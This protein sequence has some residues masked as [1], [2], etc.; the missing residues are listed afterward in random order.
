MEGALLTL[1]DKR[2]SGSVICDRKQQGR[3]TTNVNKDGESKMRRTEAK[4]SQKK[5]ATGIAMDRV[6]SKRRDTAGKGPVRNKSK[7]KE[8][9][10]E[11]LQE[12]SRGPLPNVSMSGTKIIYFL[13]LHSTQILELLNTS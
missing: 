10:W 9:S 8:G 13:I 6:L 12:L 2:P 3:S 7:L 4:T 1:R 5:S 11:M